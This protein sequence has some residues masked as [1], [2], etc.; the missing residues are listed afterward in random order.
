MRQRSADIGSFLIET[1]RGVKLAVTSNAQERE[2]ARFRKHNDSFI[3]ALMSMQWLTYFSGGL[4]G[5]ILAASTAMVFL[6]GGRQVMTGALTLGGFVAFLAFQMR[7]MP[8][9]QAMMGLYSS[10]ATARVSLRRVEELFDT[11]PEVADG[12]TQLASARGFVEFD[13]VTFAFDRAPVLED[14]TFIVNPGETIAL[15]G[16]SGSGKSTIADL[17]LR[18][19]DPDSGV[20]R[21]DGCDLRD[22][23]LAD[24]RRHIGLVEQE[25]FLFHA[26]I[27]ENL[28]Y[29]A[30]GATAAEMEEAARAAGI[31]E[32]IATLP[33]KYDTP[34]G[35]RGLALSA[36]ERQ[37]IA[38]ARALLARPAVLILDEP[39]AALDPASEDRVAGGLD[40][41]R[42]GLTTIVITHRAELAARA[43]R[44][45]M[46]EAG[47]AYSHSR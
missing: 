39:T 7:L 29:A 6:Y 27:A 17:L 31:H 28:R 45:V 32:F 25:P 34:V 24:V 35:E 16:P 5:L 1:L 23:R 4:P 3:A 13:R 19:L 10:F 37:R 9:V 44:V 20:I 2:A 18:L 22:L 47:H 43:D 12:T 33:E 41:W 26:S 42:R 46:L 40:L 21:L 14:A 11:R 15:I 8:P 36:G 30:T 38:I